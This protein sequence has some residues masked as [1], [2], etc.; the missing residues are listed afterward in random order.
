MSKDGTYDGATEG[1]KN[2]FE[3]LQTEWKQLHD[4]RKITQV[5]II[6]TWM[7]YTNTTICMYYITISYHIK[8]NFSKT[9]VT[10]FQKYHGQITFHDILKIQHIPAMIFEHTSLLVPLCEWSSLGTLWWI[11]ETMKIPSLL[12]KF[13][14]ENHCFFRRN[15]QNQRWIGTSE[16]W[17]NVRLPFWIAIPPFTAKDFDWCP[18]KPKQHRAHTKK[19]YRSVVWA[20]RTPTVSLRPP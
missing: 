2:L 7:I 19:N 14:V 15:S 12:P 1:V 8:H 4:E 6:C 13:V 16:Q 11:N 3:T 20:V 10:C 9:Y 18:C 5:L 17:R